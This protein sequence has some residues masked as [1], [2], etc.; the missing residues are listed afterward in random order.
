MAADI[1]FTVMTLANQRFEIETDSR[2]TVD[3][4]KREMEKR[5]GV[6]ADQFRLGHKGVEL[7]SG[8]T[9]ADYHITT[10]SLVL[11]IFKLKGGGEPFINVYVKIQESIETL[12]VAIDP[13]ARV[14]Q[15]KDE[16]WMRYD[17]PV[18]GQTLVFNSSI[19]E[20]EELLHS[21]GITDQ[22]T[23]TLVISSD[24]PVF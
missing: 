7:E 12:R 13:R 16:I 24:R 23:I 22:S 20:N 14:R 19:L 2:A 6:P 11:L 21:S 1:R 18:D 3:D 17:I 4:L 10:S 9:L 8:K 15:L 5:T